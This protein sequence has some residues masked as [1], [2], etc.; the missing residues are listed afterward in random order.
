M[1]IRI[2]AE[3]CVGCGACLKPCP[4]DA[5]DL[6]NRKAILNEKCV[7]CGACVDSCKFNAIIA[8]DGAAPARDLAAYKGVLVFAETR[9]GHLAKVGLELAGIGRTLADARGARLMGVVLGTQTTALANELIAHGCDE[10]FTVEDPHLEQ[11]RNAPFTRALTAVIQQSHPEIVLI[12]ATSIGRD[13]APRVA[14]RL[15]T[16]LTADCTELGIDPT[17]GLLLQTRPAFGGNVMATIVCPNHRPQMS[18]VRPGVMKPLAR[19]PNR[20][21]TVTKVTVK[22]KETDLTVIVNE[23]RRD[24]GRRV[25]LAQAEVIVAGGRGMGGP[26]PFGMLKVLADLLGGQVGAS[27]AAVESGWIDHDHQVGQT[28]KSVSPKL[29]VACGISGAI[30]HLAGIAGADY[31]IAVNR[32]PEAPIMKRADIA[33]VGE[34]QQV[35]PLLTDQIRHLRKEDAA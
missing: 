34:I 12:G 31:V 17:S 3:T 24:T 35:I 18:T 30:Q 25:D 9:H 32:D 8:E 29:Y 15:R 33:I 5:I 4:Y 16:G 2:N 10:V 7:H 11:F 27:R 14:N 23:V 19:D 22:L 20:K 26:G 21:G 1:A 13:L 28:G 6:I